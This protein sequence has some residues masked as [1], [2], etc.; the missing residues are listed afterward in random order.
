MEAERLLARLVH[1]MHR[2]LSLIV[3]QNYRCVIDG[4]RVGE[5]K[6]LRGCGL[7]TSSLDT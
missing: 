3:M 2:W 1:S 4:L 5:L 6:G 7:C